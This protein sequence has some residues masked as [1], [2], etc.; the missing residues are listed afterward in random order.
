MQN[1][2]IVSHGAAKNTGVGCQGTT[3][4]HIQGC[5]MEDTCT[6]KVHF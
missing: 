1:K 3:K 6:F 2:G 5:A 4:V